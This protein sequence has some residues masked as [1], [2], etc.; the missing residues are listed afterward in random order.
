MNLTQPS[1]YD[2]ALLHTYFL[3][4][5]N[6]EA[7]QEIM[8]LYE[9]NEATYKKRIQ[10]LE[11][12]TK[13]SFITGLPIDLKWKTL[14]TMA[15]LERPTL[16]DE[17]KVALSYIKKGYKR[18]YDFAQMNPQLNVELA[19]DF[20]NERYGNYPDAIVNYLFSAYFI[21]LPT[22]PQLLGR[23][24]LEKHFIGIYKVDITPIAR[25][26]LPIT[27]EIK[28]EALNLFTKLTKKKWRGSETFYLDKIFSEIEAKVILENPKVQR[29]VRKTGSVTSAYSIEPLKYVRFG[30]SIF[31]MLGLDNL[32]MYTNIKIT[33]DEWYHLY[34][35]VQLNQELKGFAKEDIPM[36]MCYA[37]LFFGQHKLYQDLAKQY[38]E[39]LYSINV[40]EINQARTMFE[41][42]QKL[43]Q[44]EQ[45]A[46]IAMY[47]AQI[48][49]LTENEMTLKQEKELLE[50]QLK[51]L[52]LEL[53]K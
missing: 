31:Q 37:L 51:R 30:Q 32:L 29:E 10:E 53:E 18:I 17:R 16:E 46:R 2:I 50:K 9:Q 6:E 39:Q 27:D 49:Q 21:S 26:N 47:T 36:M 5:I 28:I 25:E 1:Y 38:K 24:A 48:N 22:T 3:I 15:V 35:S 11:S 33:K 8:I 23:S 42:E 43:A 20:I 41:E 34:N 14:K 44:K 7:Y 19:V 4:A 13:S 40:N 52:Q 45:E 12:V